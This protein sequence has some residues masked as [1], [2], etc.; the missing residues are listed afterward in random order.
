MDAKLGLAAGDQLS[1]IA[2]LLELGLR[3]DLVGDTQF[4]QQL[5]DIDAAR[6]AAGRVDIGDRLGFEQRLLELIDRADGGLGRALLPT[7]PMPTE[8][9]LILLPAATL[10]PAIISSTTAGVITTMSKA[11][12]PSIRPFN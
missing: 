8:A 12:P 4:L 6:A 1:D 11:S 10:S 2:A 5:V 7:T 9:R 3:P